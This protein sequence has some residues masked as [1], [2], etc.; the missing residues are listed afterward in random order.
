MSEWHDEDPAS[1]EEEHPHGGAGTTGLP[2]VDSALARLG[3]L[4]A[5]PVDQHP[6]VFDD[7]HGRLRQ[8][9]RGDQLEG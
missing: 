7:V 2:D 6:G 5:L 8:A 9:L 4:D 3:D 1:P